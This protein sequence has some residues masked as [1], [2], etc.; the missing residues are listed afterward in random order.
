MR[1]LFSIL[2]LSALTACSVGPD[3]IKPVA[4]SELPASYKEMP[5]WKLCTPQNDRLPGKWWERYN[6]PQLNALE[7]RLTI[8][9]QTIRQAEAQYRQAS[10]LVQSA[11]AG[12]YPGVSI[13]ASATRAQRS[14]NAASSQGTS[15]GL[16]SDFLLPL[17]L[18]WEIDLWGRIRRTVEASEA[19]AAA[20]ADDLAAIRLSMQAALASNYF[21]LRILD[22]QKTLLDETVANYRKYL[23]LTNNRYQIGIAAKSDLLQAETQLKNTEAQAIDL[24]LQRAQ[25]EH[26]IALLI[27]IPASQFSLSSTILTP[28]PPEFPMA[29][30]SELLEQRPDIAAAE[31][32]MAAANAQIGAS[33]AAWF[34]AIRLSAAAGQES[35][36]ISNWLDWP[37]RFWSIGPSVSQA[38]FDG[39][40]RQAQNEQAL[41]IYDSTVAAYRQTVLTAF[42]EVEDN[43]AAL[44]ILA[45]EAQMQDEADQAA[46]RT[47]AV[48]TNQYRAGT[49]GY[50]N[51]I[52]A[53]TTELATRKTAI[54]LL[55][56]RLVA[57]VQLTKAL[58]GG[59]QN[60]GNQPL[61]TEDGSKQP[62]K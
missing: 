23:E 48:I 46:A 44:R 11:R 38:V 17:N 1:Y 21:Q 54:S 58:G 3:Y 53:Q 57:S 34:P 43:L 18:S 59:W 33:K 5:G 36:T 30:P 49:V 37:S 4:V 16:T 62:K 31:R 27:G 51:V 29:V 2:C 15:S 19:G 35:S 52:S 22:T 13:G 25:L 41:A 45:A 50:L 61:A 7:E 32:R 14:S 56:R 12:Y 28:P 10:A 47:T 39:G 40:L 8:S 26:A 9:S 24:E 6:D 60:T 55:G 20:S 42:Q